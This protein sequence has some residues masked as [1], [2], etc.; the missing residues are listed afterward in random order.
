MVIDSIIRKWLV[1]SS[2]F[3]Y[4]FANISGL[5]PDGYNQYQAGVAIGR[6]LDDRIVNHI[7]QGPT[8]DYYNHFRQIN[9]ELESLTESIVGDL[10][11]LNIKSIA[12]VPTLSLSGDE[13]RPYLKDMRYII[14]HKMVA[15]RAGLG[16]IGKTGLLVSEAF[17]PRLRL[18]SILIESVPAIIATPT[19]VSKCGTCNICVTRCP[20]RAANGISWNIE[21]D[22]DE[23]FDARKCREKCLEYGRQMFG[24]EIGI[25]GICL[26]VCPAGR[27]L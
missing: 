22:R 23:F 13:F 26:A 20:A 16:W 6:R 19:D 9:L 1:P 15:T 27:C 17:G 2:D 18:V 5:L 24:K 11:L 21:V 12:F 25:C 4:G 10:K 8:I 3:I 7:V 14:S